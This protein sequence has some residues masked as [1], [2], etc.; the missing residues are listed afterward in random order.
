MTSEKRG[1]AEIPVRILPL[2]A[3][4]AGPLA[5]LAREIWYAHYP[6]IV[7]PAQIEY[8]LAQRY[9]PRLIRAELG[10]GDVWWDKLLVGDEMAG[11]ASYF[12][13]GVPGEM[14]LDKLYVH[15]RHQR[16]GYGGM[17]VARACE[18]ARGQGC[19][20]LALAV[21]KNNRSAIA[22]YLKHGF[23]VADAVVKNI[24]GG[25]VMDDYIMEKPVVGDP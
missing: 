9:A 23:R 20:R 8:M 6:G 10:R 3:A 11:F 13:G 15:P 19:S 12:L 4:D 25:F 1:D 14:K 22:A 18:V 16:H 7:G 24:G 17:M 5:A 2:E 21:N